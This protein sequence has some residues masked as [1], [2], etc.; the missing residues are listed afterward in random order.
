MAF[1]VF[2]IEALQNLI[3]IYKADPGVL[4]RSTEPL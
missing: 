3:E 1:T 4:R 2:G